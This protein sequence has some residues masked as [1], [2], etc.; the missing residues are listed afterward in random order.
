MHTELY[1]NLLIGS[2]VTRGTQRHNGDFINL[3]FHSKKSGLKY[4]KMYEYNITQFYNSCTLFVEKK[5]IPSTYCFSDKI[6]IQIKVICP[7]SFTAQNFNCTYQGNVERFICMKQNMNFNFKPL[8]TLLF[9]VFHKTGM[10]NICSN[11]E[12]VSANEISWFHINI[13]HVL[14]PR[15]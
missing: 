14:H 2:K 5:I 3:T 7:I 15:E 9:S 1:K 10:N 4:I 11:F 8:S 6:T 12:N 13:Y